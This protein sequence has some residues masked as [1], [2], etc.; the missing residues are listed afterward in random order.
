MSLAPGALSPT[1]SPN[2]KTATYWQRLLESFGG[3]VE[4]K[5]AETFKAGELEVSHLL[6]VFHSEQT[7][8]RKLIGKEC[9]KAYCHLRAALRYRRTGPGCE[10][11]INAAIDAAPEDKKDYIY[12]EWWKTRKQWAMAYQSHFSLLLQKLIA[13]EIKAADNDCDEGEDPREIDDLSSCDCLFFQKYQLPC[14]HIW[15]QHK[16][17]GM[18][19]EEDFDR[20]NHMFDDSGF[21]IYECM[22]TEYYHKDIDEDIGAPARRR[23]DMRE[24]LDSVKSQYYELEEQV[25]DLPAARAD[26]IMRLWIATLDRITGDIR[27]AGVEEFKKQVLEADDGGDSDDS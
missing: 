1:S 2:R 12:K 21:E 14:R 18:I 7:L 13:A 8:K 10:E 16:L 24:I 4:S 15:L 25:A 9:K 11:S 23:L 27:R 17:W 6:C 26:G 3:G 22:G 5:E 20:W 19:K